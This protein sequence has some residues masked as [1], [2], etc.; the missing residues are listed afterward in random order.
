MKF[1]VFFRT[2]KVFGRKPI[3]NVSSKVTLFSL[4]KS[5]LPSELVVIC[6]NTSHSQYKWFAERMPYVY[7]TKRGNCGSFRLA[8]E[9]SKLHPANIYY[10]VEDDHLHLPQ[11]KEWLLEGLRF[12]DFVSLYDHPDKY[13]YYDYK[14]L[15]RK[16]FATKK[17]HFASSPSTVMTFACMQS[18]LK[19]TRNIFLDN[20]FTGLDR[21]YPDD[22]NL[23]LNL[24]ESGYTLG[25]SLPGRSTH[26][27]RSHLSPF[28][29]W[30]SYAIELQRQIKISRFN[31][32]AI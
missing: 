2:S 27:E 7:L 22:H 19:K 30:S 31:S 21:S 5:F 9:L 8:L 29:D 28:V 24:Y 26:C 10:F 11:Q 14:D 16:I 23:F 20:R 4:L 13:T 12:F 15:H 18:T 32:L 25:T 6:D 3:K 17:G 1:C